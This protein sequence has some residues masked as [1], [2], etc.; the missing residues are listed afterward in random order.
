[1][2]HAPV[3]SKEYWRPANPNVARLFDPDSQSACWRCGAQYHPGAHFCH[4]C[5]YGR[6]PES[7]IP[8]RPNEMQASSTGRRS[9]F[10]L[11]LPWTSFV[12][13]VLAVGCLVG[14]ALM[15]AIYRTDTLVDWQAIQIWRIEWLLAAIAALIAGLLLK[16]T[17][18]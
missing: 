17:E 4:V 16:K 12:C 3:S 15:G 18:S 10:L 14:A 5:G 11:W 13:F 9:P 6:E 8:T 2:A 1:M 7:S